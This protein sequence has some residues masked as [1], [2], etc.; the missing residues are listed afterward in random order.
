MQKE[1]R[2]ALMYFEAKKCLVVRQAILIDITTFCGITM[3]W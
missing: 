3:H 2:A 1:L